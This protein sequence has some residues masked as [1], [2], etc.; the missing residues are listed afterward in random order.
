MKAKDI[1]ETSVITV[2]PDTTIEELAKVLTENNISGV[3]VVENEKIIGIVTEGDLLHK[4][5]NPKTP[6]VYSVMGGF[7]YLKEFEKYKLELQKLSAHKASEIMTTKL[8]L[9]TED[10]EIKEIA[11]I[12][13]NKNINRVPVV[14]DG[15]LVG[16]VSR[17]D[18][19]KTLA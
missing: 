9:V 16:I 12:M 11:S 14:R 19:L 3:P 15:K 8:E 4:E 13:I 17:A 2:D 7:A 6:G 10:T 1:M 5:V 18:V